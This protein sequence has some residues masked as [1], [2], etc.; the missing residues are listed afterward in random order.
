MK[1]H[2]KS[3]SRVAYFKKA[4]QKQRRLQNRLATAPASKLSALQ[5]KIAL[6]EK[7]IFQMNRKWSFGIAAATL[8]LWFSNPA[9]AQLADTVHLDNLNGQNDIIVFSDL[10]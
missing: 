1:K 10:F 4:L 9:Q 6:L 3:H 5:R 8:L 7:R 2:Y